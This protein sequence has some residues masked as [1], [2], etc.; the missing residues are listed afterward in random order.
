MLII[1]I[2]DDAMADVPSGKRHLASSEVILC[3]VLDDTGTITVALRQWREGDDGALD[4][5]SEA[6]YR[7]LRRVAGAILAQRSS[8]QIVHPTELVHDLYLQIQGVQHFDFAGRA[9]FLSVAGKMMRRILVDHAR[10]RHSAKRGGDAIHVTESGAVGPGLNLE[11]LDVHLALE[12]F[13]VDYPRQ[14]RVVELRFF[15]GLSAGES[16]EV[17]Q[18][19]GLEAS[20]RTVERDWTFAKA[21]L[22]NAIRP[23]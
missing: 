20:L 13:A 12:R 22:Q 16:A 19:E 18:L 14:A 8:L 5:L 17:L 23:H 1:V 10:K 2:L 6:V 15:G 7:Q 4:R 3:G 11:V 21:W 9:Q